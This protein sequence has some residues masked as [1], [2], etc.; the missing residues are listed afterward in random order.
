MDML[1]IA[2][3]RSSFRADERG[4]VRG[5]EAKNKSDAR[6]VGARFSILLPSGLLPL[7]ITQPHC[8][9][10]PYLWVFVTFC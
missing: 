8:T 1:T 3:G 6:N 5:R 2:F 7:H 10:L 4:V 9:L